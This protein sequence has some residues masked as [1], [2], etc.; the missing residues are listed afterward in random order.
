MSRQ[1]RF[2]AW[3]WILGAGALGWPRGMV[4]GGRR[5]EGS[6]WGTRVYLWQ[7]HVDIWQNQY[8]IVKLKKKLE[9][10]AISFSN[11]W[12]WKVK[13]KSLCRAQ[14]LA[15]AWTTAYQAPPSMGVSRQEYWSG[16]PLPS[17]FFNLNPFYFSFCQAGKGSAWKAGYPGLILG[18]GRSP[19][20]VTDYPHRGFPGGWD[21]WVESL[22]WKDH[23]EEGLATHS[24]VL[25]WRIPGTGEPGGLPSMGSHRVRHDWSDLAAAA[26]W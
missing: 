23:L 12:K 13:G 26:A 16:L 2:D 4:Q 17:P 3:Y 20:E 8:N 7:I 11:A 9:W 14:L 24:S 10:V 6:G 21:V 18:L 5:E 1:P 15:T 22:A 25:A 19:G